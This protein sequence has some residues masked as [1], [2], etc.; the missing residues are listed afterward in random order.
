MIKSVSVLTILLVAV[1]TVV[2]FAASAANP[3][4]S[5]SI[6][7]KG[8]LTKTTYM[9]YRGTNNPDNKWGVKMTHSN[10]RTANHPDGS[11]K[12]VTKFWLGVN[13]PNG[14][15]PLGSTKVNVTEGALTYT[16][17]VAY[18]NASLENVYLYAA[19]NSSTNSSYQAEGYWY[20]YTD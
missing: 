17:T 16:K 4:Y 8:N 10:E 9:L 13:N 2:P 20:A 7:A 14:I 6:P 15:N 1:M 19:D 12:T 11:A 18:R 5:F 3:Y